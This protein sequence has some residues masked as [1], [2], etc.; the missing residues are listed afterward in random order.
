METSSP[1]LLGVHADRAVH[2]FHDHLRNGQPQSG[3]GGEIVEFDE[4]V[5]NVADLLFGNAHARI[6]DI[7]LHA[8]VLQVESEADRGP[9][10]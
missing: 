8:V 7:E 2:A 10:R 5:E 1:A 3:S 4:A 9:A 6:L